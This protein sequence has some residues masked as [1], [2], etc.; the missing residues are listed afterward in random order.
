MVW[1][2]CLQLAGQGIYHSKRNFVN[3][4]LSWTTH[5]FGAGGWGGSIP[6]QLVQLDGVRAPSGF[7]FWGRQTVLLCRPQRVR[8]ESH[9][10]PRGKAGPFE[11]A[12]TTPLL[13]ILLS[14]SRT[15]NVFI[16]DCPTLHL[17]CDKRFWLKYWLNLK[18][19][20]G[21]N[22]VFCLPL[23]DNYSNPHSTPPN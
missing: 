22:T 19:P 23:V 4:S 16:L 10:S 6:I 3:A 12:R 20:Q 5:S 7:A 11:E 15:I 21:E 8:R 9:P 1:L 13:L 17:M 18:E 2:D 14:H